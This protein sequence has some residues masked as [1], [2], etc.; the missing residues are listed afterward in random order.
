MEN[1]LVSARKY[2][3]DTFDTVIGQQVI[4]AT[5]KSAILSG[6]LA[7]AY[8]FC[9][10]RG[11]GKTTCARI[12]AKT[13]NCQ[14]IGAD[15]EP[16]NQCDSCKSFN[17][18]RSF[19]IHEL[20]AAS[21]NSVDDIRNLI[22]SVR[23][24]PQSGKYSVYIIDE[25]HML[26]QQAFNA[27]L[28]TLEEPPAHAVFILATTEKHK[29]IPTILSRCQIYDF[30]RIRVEDIVAYL[31]KIAA[32]EEVEVEEEALSVIALKADGAM[33]DA[34][35]I[36]DQL[37]SYSQHSITYKGVIENLNVLDY[38]YYFTLT[39]CFLG[40]DIARSL[41]VLNEILLKGFDGFNFVS[42]LS[43]HLRDVMISRDAITL[44]LLETGESIRAR[45]L[46]QARRCDPHFLYRALD[47]L[48][49]CEIYYKSSRNQRLHMEITLIR[50]CNPNDEKKT[51]DGTAPAAVKKTIQTA[52]DDSPAK[53]A[54]PASKVNNE[55]SADEA[56]DTDKE[57][58]VEEKNGTYKKEENGTYPKTVRTIS[59]KDALQ[60]LENGSKD[61]DTDPEQ[62]E[63][64]GT[65]SQAEPVNSAPIVK[66]FM[67]KCWNAYADLIREEKPRFSSALKSIEPVIKDDYVIEISFSNQSQ[68]DAFQAKVKK[69]LELFLRRE[70]QQ[71]RISIETKI[72]PPD[73]Q[74][75]KLY[76]AD[77]KLAYLSQKNPL[78][79]RLVKDLGLELE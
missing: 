56:S 8:L 52:S 15:A 65:M 7:H 55:P 10:P 32:S 24:I 66:E 36:F 73:E 35:T 44:P 45:Y 28:K 31:K 72:S 48:N 68:I 23:I 1:F 59:I 70:L 71:P 18:S 38:D 26:S 21:N 37:V 61:S 51:P 57:Q 62:T 33:R 20:D 19:N 4:T 27:F 12:F 13:I 41:L 9:G 46:E 75:K 60:E 39:D 74:N 25:V 54:I 14:H 63:T 30:N 16:C 77:D 67:F 64:D 49:Q 3:P 42:G 2:R 5:L 6:H 76:T 78:L 11:V 53:S 79:N 40:H 47:I 34:L 58:V 29:I 43:K 17:E 22:E 69:G 50:L